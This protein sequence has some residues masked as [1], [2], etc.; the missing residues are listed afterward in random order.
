MK[1]PVH[2]IAMLALLTLMAFAGATRAEGVGR[3]LFQF[4]FDGETVKEGIPEPWTLKVKNGDAS[5]RIVSEGGRKVLH[6]V[7]NDSSFSLQCETEVDVRKFPHLQ[8]SWMVLKLPPEGD[9]RKGKTNDQALQLLLA[10]EKKKIISYVWDSNAPEGTISDESVGWPVNLKI[11]VVVVRSG[12]ADMG[13]WVGL[14]R[15]VYDD[16]V[17]LFG[18]EPGLLKGVRVQT[19]CQHTGAVA[20][21]FF[22]EIHLQPN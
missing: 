17:R 20:E 5:V 4:E 13:N 11:K 21:G 2:V 9:L 3:E 18:E 6:L 1:Y 19:N 8:W 16:Y 22:G 7:C 14:E 12:K 15:N 10:F